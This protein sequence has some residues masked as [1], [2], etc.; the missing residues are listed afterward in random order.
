[1][2]NLDSILEF[3]D[4]RK[5]IDTQHKLDRQYD[6]DRF[7]YDDNFTPT[8]FEKHIQRILNKAI[9][10]IIKKY[11]DKPGVYVIHSYST[12]IGIVIEWRPDRIKD[13]GRNHA[14]I[15]TLLPM[16]KDHYVKKST[17]SKIVV[18][19]QVK[20]FCNLIMKKTEGRLVESADCFYDWVDYEGHRFNFFSGKLIE[21]DIN[22]IVVD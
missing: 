6:D 21:T 15:V 13:D 11:G 16:A 10:K 2:F 18:E 20:D 12:K 3:Y 9:Q 14:I 8:V 5:I 7:D 22:I 19:Q 4:N 17:D 1:M